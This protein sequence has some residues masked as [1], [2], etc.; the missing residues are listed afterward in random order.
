MSYTAVAVVRL[1]GRRARLAGE[2]VVGGGGRL[3][4]TGHALCA[5]C[6]RTQHPGVPAPGE[7]VVR[8]TDG[9]PVQI[10]IL[11]NQSCVNKTSIIISFEQ[12]KCQIRKQFSVIL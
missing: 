1:L 7:Y 8:Q 10:E 2:V 3:S 5:L 9:I 6:E 11:I 12:R 4:V